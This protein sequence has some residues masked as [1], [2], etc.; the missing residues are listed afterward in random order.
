[1][2]TLTRYPKENRVLLNANP[3]T[4]KA[5]TDN[6]ATHYFRVVITVND[7]VEIEESWSKLNNEVRIDLKDFYKN[8]FAEILPAFDLEGFQRLDS[9]K[10]KVDV[11]INEYL[12]VDDSLIESVDAPTFY[13]IQAAIPFVFDDLQKFQFLPGQLK[14]LNVSA[15]SKVTFAFYLNTSSDLEYNLISD[16]EAVLKTGTLSNAASGIYVA[17]IDLTNIELT[18]KNYLKIGDGTTNFDQLVLTPFFNSIYSPT[19]LYFKNR[20][21]IYLAATLFGQQEVEYNHTKEEY[22]LA[23]ESY[24][25]FSVKTE[26]SIKVN[27]GHLFKQQLSLVKAINEALDLYMLYEGTYKMVQVISKKSAGFIDGEF[28]YSDTLEFAFQNNTPED[29]SEKF[30]VV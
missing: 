4:I 9:L 21:G 26:T 1:M 5:T 7:T 14:T 22:Q 6:G 3:C 11:T 18:A 12:L 17:Q 29:N 23:D 27:T 30:E 10:I 28:L 20:N 13:M 16:K 8:R 24:K 19:Q 2:I 15:T 25:T